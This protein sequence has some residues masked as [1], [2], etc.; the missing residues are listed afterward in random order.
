[1]NATANPAAIITIIR[2]EWAE[3]Y[4]NTLVLSVV[5]LLPLIFVALPLGILFASGQFG[6]AGAII[7][8][9]L[10][11]N[12]LG[13]CTNLTGS[14]CGQLVIVSQFM[15]LFMMVPMIIPSTIAPYSI[16]GEKTQRT[17]EPILATPISTADLLVAKNLASIIPAVLATW[18]AFGL[19]AIGAYFLVISGTVYARLFEPRWILAVFF[20]GPLLALFSAALSII[21]SSR[22]NDPRAAQQIASLVILPIV[23]LFLGQVSGLILF[24]ATIVLILIAA[25]IVINIILIFISVRIFDRETILTRWA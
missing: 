15:L 8:D 17:L 18:A 3:L 22:A 20:L 4:K 23:L 16:V 2:K 10:P 9:E 12:A 11:A 24:S 19:F 6:D 5:L 7:T 1:M 25:M 21:V 13:L 14:E